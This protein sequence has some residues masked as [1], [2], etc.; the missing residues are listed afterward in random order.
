MKHAGV[1]KKSKKSQLERREAHVCTH[2]MP[3]P[4]VTE[5][6]CVKYACWRKDMQPSSYRIDSR[7]MANF[8]ELC[9]IS[10]PFIAEAAPCYT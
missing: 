4:T 5:S 6:C 7:S 2:S 9:G 3:Q 8:V 10:A 1:L